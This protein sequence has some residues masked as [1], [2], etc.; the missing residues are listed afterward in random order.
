MEN[1]Q[2][3]SA[4]LVI[5]N[6]VTRRGFFALVA[7][8]AVGLATSACTEDGE[9]NNARGNH[10]DCDNQALTRCIGSTDL[11]CAKDGY[12]RCDRQYP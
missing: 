12:A 8:T 1:K 5:N 11:M 7:S 4:D 2:S 6:K 10:L 9:T 3:L